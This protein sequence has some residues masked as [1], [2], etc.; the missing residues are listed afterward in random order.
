M[1]LCSVCKKNMAVIFINKLDKDGKSTNESTGLCVECAKKQGID[2]LANIMKEMEKI[3]PEDMENMSKQFDEMLGNIN[4]DENFDENE[5]LDDPK[6]K[7]GLHNLFSN[8]FLKRNDISKDETEDNN[9][10]GKK[11]KKK[12]K[13]LDTFGENLT[14]KARDNKLDRV[15]G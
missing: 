4:F 11:S 12:T 1:V 9:K 6:S 3:S 5:D 2:P 13:Y 14:Q 7:L 10:K 15:I 8:S